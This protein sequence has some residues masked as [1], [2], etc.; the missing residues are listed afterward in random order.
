[1]LAWSIKGLAQGAIVQ[2]VRQAARLGTTTAI[3]RTATYQRRHEALARIA[4]A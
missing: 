3:G 1:M 2:F 4:N